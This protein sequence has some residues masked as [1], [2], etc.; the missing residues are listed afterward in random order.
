[1]P[2]PYQLVE[3][4]RGELLI[5]WKIIRIIILENEQKLRREENKPVYS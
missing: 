4:D 3:V 2:C 1:M 5:Y